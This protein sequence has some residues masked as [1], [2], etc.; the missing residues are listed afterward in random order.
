MV[1]PSEALAY[2]RSGLNDADKARM[3]KRERKNKELRTA[4]ETLKW[5]RCNLPGHCS[6]ADSE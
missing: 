6:T 1:H 2:E 5:R 4:N 3:N